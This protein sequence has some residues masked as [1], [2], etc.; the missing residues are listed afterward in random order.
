[1]MMTAIGGFSRNR[2]QTTENLALKTAN[3]FNYIGEPQESH[4]K[5]E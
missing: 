5:N 3:S 1:M 2:T 4:V